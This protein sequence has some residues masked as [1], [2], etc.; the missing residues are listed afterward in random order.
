[1]I[2]SVTIA[3]TLS[4]TA[5]PR[6]TELADDARSAVVRQLEGSVRAAS[7][8]AHAQCVVQ[9]SCAFRSGVGTV[10]MGG[11]AVH[12]ERGYPQAG[13]AQGIA[14]AVQLSGFEV[15]HEEGETVFYLAQ[16]PE[17]MTCA[18]RYRAPQ[19]DGG[20]PEVQARTDGC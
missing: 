13:H 4:A 18:V 7:A 16:A 10:T 15:R 3:G 17:S 1:M 14:A 2:C 11:D 6:L 5:L 12:L 9:P 20:L 19:T 8:L